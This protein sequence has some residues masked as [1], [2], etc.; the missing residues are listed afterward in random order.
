MASDR[1][2]TPKQEDFVLQ[3]LVDFCG[4]QAAI[5]AGYSP[6]NADKLASQ[7][8][9][10]PRVRAAIDRARGERAARVERTAL[11]VLRDIQEVTRQARDAGQYKVA[12]RGL[13]LEGKHIGMFAEKLDLSMD[14]QL[15]SV[16][17][18]ARNRVRNR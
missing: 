4:K 12:L 3:Y 5:R 11:D 2:L 8:L 16:I 7:L 14:V 10:N 17:E 6:R 13:E 15:S 9:G 18:E 1:S